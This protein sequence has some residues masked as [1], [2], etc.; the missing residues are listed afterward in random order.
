VLAAAA[1][2]SAIGDPRAGGGAARREQ[3][4]RHGMSLALR[5][6]GRIRRQFGLKP[7]PPPMIARAL[8]QYQIGRRSYGWV[9]VYADG[10]PNTCF[11]MGAYCSV[12][13]ECK[14]LIG[15]E[16]RPDWVT[17][18]P[19]SV[20]EPSLA[21]IP[22]QPASRG[23]V[24]I[25]NDVWIGMEAMILSGVT[26]GDGA[27]VAARA[28]VTRDVPPY[29]IVGGVPAKVLS[30][31]FDDA[32]IARLLALKWW[33]WPHDRIVRAGEY[34]LSPDIGR[35]LDLAERGEI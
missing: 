31:R 22:G 20:L 10:L 17:T 23:D 25:G 34:M 13:H 27:V 4:E 2:G 33:D 1:G 3:D 29:A 24:V 15:L 16:H 5:I 19:F 21:H 6:A 7:S 14:V 11:R 30:K 35:F 18:Y 26:I 32:T 12:A 28:L 9:R 8:P